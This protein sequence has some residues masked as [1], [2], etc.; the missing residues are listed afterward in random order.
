V[1]EI[2]F[3]FLPGETNPSASEFKSKYFCFPSSVI[4]PVINLGGS[5]ITISNCLFCRLS[6]LANENESLCSHLNSVN[7]GPQ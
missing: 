7:G 6:I 5:K 1:R 3:F 2:F 4:L